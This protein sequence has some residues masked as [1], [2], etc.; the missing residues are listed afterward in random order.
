MCRVFNCSKNV[1]MLVNA[2][3]LLVGLAI[4]SVGGWAAHFL[5]NWSFSSVD[6]VGIYVALATGILMTLTSLVGLCGACKANTK[7]RAGKCYLKTYALLLFLVVV[8]QLAA[9]VLVLMWAGD[10]TQLKT[11]LQNH[12]VNIDGTESQLNKVLDNIYTDCCAYH[13]KGFKPSVDV[14]GKTIS[15]STCDLIS[16]DPS[17]GNAAGEVAFK[18][19]IIDFVNKNIRPVGVACLILGASELLL[20]LAS[21]YLICSKIRKPNPLDDDLMTYDYQDVA[22]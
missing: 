12:K 14:D 3:L 11:D 19:G 2:V 7:N 17:C 10:L 21:C 8:L 20:L 4:T 13:D 22:V 18:Q 5:S 16:K 1:L 6:T 15:L 9:G